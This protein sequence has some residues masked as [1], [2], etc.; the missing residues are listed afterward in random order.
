MAFTI[1]I[2][3]KNEYLFTLLRKRLSSFF[4][5]AYIIDPYYETGDQDYRFSEYEKVLYDPRDIKKEDI[6]SLSPPLRLTDD[7]GIIDC[8]SFLPFIRQSIESPSLLRP[9]TGTV[10]AV[11]P[12]VYSDV[13]DRFISNLGTDLTGADFNIRLDFTSR[14]RSLCRRSAG[15]NMTSLLDAC[16]SRKFT[17]EDILKYCNMDDSGF[18]TPGAT[19]N[20]DDVYDLGIT[21]SITLMNLA[22]DLAHSKTRFVNVVAVI[23]GFRTKDLPDLL[24]STDNVILLMPAKDAG[25]DIGAK[26]L[27]ELLTRTLGSERVSVTYAEDLKDAGVLDD[28]LAPRRQVV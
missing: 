27:I 15:S 4:P 1:K 26:D 10:T 17:P 2:Y 11:L 14:L 22:S 28:S 9:A 23:E 19:S 6:V 18:L 8:A 20:N 5:D 7:G 3:E 21:R 25:E 16:R 12:F 13:R 24:S